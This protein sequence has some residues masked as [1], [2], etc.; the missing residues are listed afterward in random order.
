MELGPHASFIVIAYALA[1]LVFVLL[2]GWVVVD[3]RAL[4]HSLEELEMRGVT[5]RSDR[6]GRKTS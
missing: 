5:R 3:H 1:A 6:G 4:K 2:I